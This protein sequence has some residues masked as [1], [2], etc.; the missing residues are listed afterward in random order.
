MRRP[1]ATIWDTKIQC[2]CSIVSAREG[3]DIELWLCGNFGQVSLD[4]PRIAVNPNRLYPI[5]PAI[6]RERRFAIGILSEKQRDLALRLSRIGRRTIHKP[7]LL[8]LEMAEHQQFAIPYAPSCPRTLFCEAEDILD[9]GDHTLIVARVLESRIQPHAD[10]ERPLL[11]RSVAAN[12]S[13]YP[14]VSQAL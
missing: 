10:S 13:P 1:A 3:D 6:R 14:R 11:Y 7:Q 4:D 9:T 2:V 12:S 5:E 8:E